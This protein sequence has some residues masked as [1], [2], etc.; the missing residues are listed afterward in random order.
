M[1]ELSIAMC[2]LEAA[3]EEA[4]RHGGGRVSAVHLKIGEQSGVVAGALCSAFEL[5]REQS[6]LA[7]CKLVIESVAGT[8]LLVSA[9]ELTG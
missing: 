3:E 7:E 1:H 2:I 5:A 9:L 8:E 4:E 6:P